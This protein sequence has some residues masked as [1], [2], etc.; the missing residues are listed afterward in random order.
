MTCMNSL[1]L[2]KKNN[3][4]LSFYPIY[5]I[6]GKWSVQLQNVVPLVIIFF[7]SKNGYLNVH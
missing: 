1:F 2:M 4:H 3:V 5:M 6:Y 7:F